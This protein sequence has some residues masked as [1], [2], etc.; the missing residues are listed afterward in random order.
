MSSSS[1]G[2]KLKKKQYMVKIKE[3]TYISHQQC[4]QVSAID[5]QATCGKKFN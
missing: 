1:L 2:V 4:V 3:L 5:L